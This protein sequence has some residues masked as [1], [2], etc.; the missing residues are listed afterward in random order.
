MEIIR[1]G[2]AAGKIWQVIDKNKIIKISDLKKIT[3]MDIK[4]LYLAL[5][6]LAREN[7][8][9]FFEKDRELAVTLIN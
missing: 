9:Q 1:L 8:V 6:W 7:K 4:D 2:Y 5:G 3:R